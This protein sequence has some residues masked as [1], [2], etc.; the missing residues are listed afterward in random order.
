MKNYAILGILILFSINVFSQTKDSTTTFKVQK[1]EN[2]S[3]I[4]YQDNITKEAPAF[5][6]VEQNATFNG[7]DINTFRDWINTNITYPQEALKIGAE[8]MVV[9]NFT[10]NNSGFLVNANILKSSGFKSL[11]DEAI[12]AILSSSQWI[13]AQLGGAIVAQQFNI[14]IVFKLKK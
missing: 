5:L 13:P 12:R 14:P 2:K 8:G 7:G 10:V 6:K 3:D 11:D 9:V 4:I 1:T